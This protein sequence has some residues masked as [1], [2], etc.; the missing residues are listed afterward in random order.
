VI[1]T[2]GVAAEPTDWRAVQKTKKAQH[3]LAEPLAQLPIDWGRAVIASAL[4]LAPT[5]YELAPISQYKQ[6]APALVNESSASLPLMPL[7]AARLISGTQGD[8]S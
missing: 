4:V 7:G 1:L 8:G 3:R 6:T 5:G 2:K